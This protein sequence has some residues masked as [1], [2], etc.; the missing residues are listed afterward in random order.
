MKGQK[1]TK[2]GKN[3][4]KRRKRESKEWNHLEKKKVNLSN[5]NWS[6]PNGRI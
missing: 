5:H 6:L 4:H 3:K 1:K 2:E